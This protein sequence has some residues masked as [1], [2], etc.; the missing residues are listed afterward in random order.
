MILTTS[1]ED[2]DL[3]EA[4]KAGANGYLLKSMDAESLIEALHDAQQDI[5]PF[6]PG[7]AARLLAE[8]GRMAEPAATSVSRPRVPSIDRRTEEPL[9]PA[10]GR[11]ARAGRSG[12][13][14]QGS[15]R[16]RL[17]EPSHRQ[18]PHGRDHP[19]RREAQYASASASI[20]SS[21]E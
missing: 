18:V 8:F 11:G 6:A 15:R 17:P 21:R 16:A 7:L 1:T 20:A 13:L 10:P 9:S 12:A 5:P 19:Q 2:Q 14:L 4:V 3:F